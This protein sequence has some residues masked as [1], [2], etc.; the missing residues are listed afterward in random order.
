MS[1]ISQN[2]QEEEL[3][4]R[5]SLFFSDFKIGDLLRRCNANKQ[6]GIPVI[7]IFKYKLCNIFSD[8][9]MYMQQKTNA[10]R[11]YVLPLCLQS[12]FQIL[13]I[14]SRVKTGKMPL[15][16]MTA[17]SNAQASKNATRSKGFDH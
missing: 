9:S 11:E 16:S 7:D 8:L 2:Q 13:S 4:N 10:F 15:S 17:F 5:I 3:F 14:H 6:K 1:I 12:V